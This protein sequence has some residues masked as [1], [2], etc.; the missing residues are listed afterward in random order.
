MGH[1]YVDLGS[2]RFL[3]SF[4]RE[5]SREPVGEM[6]ISAYRTGGHLSLGSIFKALESA[7]QCNCR[8]RCKRGSDVLKIYT[9][10]MWLFPFSFL[11]FLFFFNAMFQY[12]AF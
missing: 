2:S 8:L 3:I 10:G 9:S 12:F 7:S 6:V 5:W 4:A 1:F 11:N